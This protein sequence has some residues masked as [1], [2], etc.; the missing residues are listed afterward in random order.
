LKSL[1]ASRSLPCPVGL[2]KKA[3]LNLLN[4]INLGKLQWEVGSVQVRW[5]KLLIQ[6]FVWLA[7]EM[8]LNFLGLDTLANYSEFVFHRNHMIIQG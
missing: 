1:P 8:F 5:Q 7:I 2:H 4:I 3:K 6:V